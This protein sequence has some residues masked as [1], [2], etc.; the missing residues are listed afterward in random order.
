VQTVLRAPGLLDDGGRCPALALA[1][2][3]T[4]E[5]VM[6][7][8]P[9]GFDEDPAEMR[10]AGFGDAAARLFRAT[11]IF[12]RDEAGEGHDARGG[13][14]AAGV[15]QFRGDGQRGE[16]VDAAEAAEALDARA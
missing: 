10:V 1:Q 8:V 11:R 7:V 13:R 14:K 5:G 15:A 2:R 12:G 4:E 9:R 16:I 6:P 3:V